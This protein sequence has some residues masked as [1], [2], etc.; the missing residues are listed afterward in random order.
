MKVTVILILVS[1]HL[2]EPQICLSI[3]DTAEFA[4]RHKSMDLNLLKYYRTAEDATFGELRARIKVK[5]GSFIATTQQI[6]KTTLDMS[7]FFVAL[8]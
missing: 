4:F 7:D 3:F 5:I 8:L 1:L 6:H 2:A